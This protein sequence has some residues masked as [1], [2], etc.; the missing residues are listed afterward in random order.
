MPAQSRCSAKKCDPRRQANTMLSSIRVIFSF[1]LIFFTNRLL[2]KLF[3]YLDLSTTD[4]LG[5]QKSANDGGALEI[6]LVPR[7]TPTLRSQ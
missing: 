7:V 3:S 6:Q 2:E 5:V 1:W 4:A